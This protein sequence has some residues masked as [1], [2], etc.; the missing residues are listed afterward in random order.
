MAKAKRILLCDD[1]AHILRAAEFKFKRAG[2]EVF[3]AFDGQEGWEQLLEHRPDIVVTDCQMPRLNGLQLAERIHNTPETKGL[4]VI[5]LSAK[6][7]ELSQPDIHETF[8]IM[9]LLP[10]PFSPRELFQRVEATLARQE[11]PT[12]EIRL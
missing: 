12:P 8:G 11:L 6:G 7:F 2:Y 9:A 10:K 3:C 1:E 5:M 4:P